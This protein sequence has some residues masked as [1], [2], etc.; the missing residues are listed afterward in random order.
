MSIINKISEFISD[1]DIYKIDS[2]INQGNYFNHSEK[3]IIQIIIG[4]ADSRT[5]TKNE[6]N[7]ALN[8][9]EEVLTKDFRH[10]ETY[11]KR[12]ETLTKRLKNL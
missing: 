6:I 8:V 2:D 7:L 1:K 5:V 3:H 9:L 12:Y 11:K 10:H 4:S